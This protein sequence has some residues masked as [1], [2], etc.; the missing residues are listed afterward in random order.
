MLPRIE[1]GAGIRE[2]AK[3]FE[4]IFPL[5]LLQNS[6]KKYFEIQSY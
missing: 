3:W 1:F 5:P 2:R 6:Y 4:I